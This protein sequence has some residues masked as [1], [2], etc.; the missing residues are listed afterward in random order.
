LIAEGRSGDV[1]ADNC[2]RFRAQRFRPD[3]RRNE[4]QSKGAS[5]HEAAAAMFEGH[6]HL[7]TLP[8]DAVDVMPL[9]SGKPDA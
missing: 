9:L 1:V 3:K 8:C 2:G 7:T 6:P 4:A 5:S